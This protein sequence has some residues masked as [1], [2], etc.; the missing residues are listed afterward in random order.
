[1]EGIEKLE[2]FGTIPGDGRAF[3]AIHEQ[4]LGYCV[5]AN[6]LRLAPQQLMGRLRQRGVELEPL[7]WHDSAFRWP[8]SSPLAPGQAA[9]HGLG[10]YWVQEEAAIAA[11]AALPVGPD[12]RVLDLCAAPGMK[13]A[14]L[15]VAMKN[16]GTLVANDFRPGRMRA[17]AGNLERLGVLNTTLTH[18]DGARFPRATG[19]FDRVLVDAPCSCLGTARKNPGVLLRYTPDVSRRKSV[20]QRKL[21]LRALE[22]CKPGGLVA[23]ITCTY[24]PEENEAVVQFVLD[25][26]LARLRPADIPGLRVT[27]GLSRWRTER[28]DSSMRHCARIWPHLND[29]GGFFVALL[30]RRNAP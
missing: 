30:A 17:L 26:G 21:L 29:S 24:P 27:E 16:R 15:A 1:M 5:S 8:R 19:L 12:H 6:L 20:L 3:V 13:T 11:I 28:F 18:C 7:P 23:Y 25:R 10:L 9:E 2:P 4:E 22:L 14:T